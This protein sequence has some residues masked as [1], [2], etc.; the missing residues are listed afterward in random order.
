[1]KGIQ[2]KILLILFILVPVPF[3]CEDKNECLDLYVEPYFDI[4]DMVFSYVDLYSFGKVNNLMFDLVSQDYATHVYPCDSMALYI[5]V[6]DTALLFHSQQVM[7]PRFGFTPEAFAC[8]AR[9]NGYA[10][11][12]ELVDKIYISSNYDFDETHN[13]TDNLSDI[14]DIFAYTTND[15]NDWMSL[16]DYNKSSPYEAPKRFYLLIKRKPTRSMIQQFVITY[17]MKTEPGEVTESYIIT[18]PVF[19]VR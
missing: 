14:V 12:R 13:K 4:Q 6:P 18:T 16:S 15:K 1:M 8:N 11:T 10:G 19:H 9:R 3:S 5:M 7:R 17:Y 2:L